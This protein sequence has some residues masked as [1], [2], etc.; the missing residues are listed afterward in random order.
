MNNQRKSQMYGDIIESKATRQTL[1]T[2]TWAVAGC[3]FV[4][5]LWSVFT[6]V[7]EIAKSH[8][9]VIPEGELQVVQSD[10]G[11]K[12]KSILVKE[13]E[14]VELNQPIVEFDATF[15]KAA[16]AELSSQQVTLQASIERLDALIDQR[17]P[18][19]SA[20]ED[21][22]PEIVNQQM[23]QFS[24]R[25]STYFQRR[26]ELVKKS[27]EIAEQLNSIKKSIPAYKRQV[28]A[29]R[30]ELG[31]LL[32][33][34][35]SGNISTLRVLEMRQTLAAKQQQYQEALGK[36]AVFL[37]QEDGNKQK[38]KRLLA[39]SK[40]ELSDR[41]SKAVSELSALKGRIS[42]GEAKLSNTV[43][44]SPVQGL[45]QSLP[46]TKVGAVI[47]PGGTVAEIVPVGGQAN[48]K[49][50]LSPR[51]VGFVSIGQSARVKIDAFDY[52]RF[53]ALKGKV[54]SISPTTSKD[55]KGNIFYD[56]IISVDKSY[57]QN[58]PEKFSIL[59]G[60]TGEVDITTGQKS[61][62]QYL[63]KP[64]YTNISVAFGER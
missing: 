44:V 53:G 51:D 41:R 3:V 14:L 29:A 57:F 49:A 21:K 27:E 43:L 24:A 20:F 1:M 63:W 17:K 11:G 50:Q 10:I 40:L 9:T 22:Y 37:K 46:N 38:I 16:L 6:Q 52:S 34:H 59:P 13:G 12:L 47:P 19:F 45:V 42:S 35:K 31:L 64:I 25:V 5:S 55:Q 48:F 23:Q 7:D 4:F 61:V 32:K 56:V 2:A 36:K 18:D 28:S 8:G 58:N 39:E 62:F 30:Q 15:Q 26:I 33:G 60:M 54:K